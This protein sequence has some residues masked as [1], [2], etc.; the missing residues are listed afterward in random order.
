MRLKVF[1]ATHDIRQ[2][3]IIES[4]GKTTVHPMSPSQLSLILNGKRTLTDRYKKPMIRALKR[5]GF[6]ESQISKIDELK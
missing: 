1:M 6:D 3:S 2:K 4:L 5:L